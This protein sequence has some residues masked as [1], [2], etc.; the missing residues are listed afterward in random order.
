MIKAVAEKPRDFS[1]LAEKQKKADRRS[2]RRAIFSYSSTMILARVAM[3]VQGVFVIRW[4]EPVEMG[5][6]LSILL[7]PLYGVHAHLG[8]LNAI[9]LKVPYYNGQGKTEQAKRIE[10]VVRTNIAIYLLISLILVGLLYLLGYF[11]GKIGHGVAIVIVCAVITIGVNFYS[12]LFRSKHQF[13][14][15]GVVSIANAMLLIIGLP[16]VYYFGYDGLLIRYLV[17]S[18][19]L[20]IF[21]VAILSRELSIEFSWDETK[22]LILVGFPIMILSYGIVFF[23]SMDRTM[24]LFFLDKKAMG[25][26]ALAI[27]AAPIVSLLPGLVGQIYYPRMTEIFSA[28]GINRALAK[29]CVNASLLSAGFAAVVCLALAV[30]APPLICMLFPKYT[31]GITSMQIVLIG[32]FALSLGT[33]PNYFL[34]ST[35]QKKIQSMALV[36]GVIITLGSGCILVDNGLEGIAVAVVIGTC[37]Y[38]FLIWAIVYRSLL[39]S[40]KFRANYEGCAGIVKKT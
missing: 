37:S 40:S 12:G 15:A 4:L 7:I 34:I 29:E 23:S 25:E 2:L 10:R 8:L 6:W 35:S 31:G 20:L 19:I 11:K 36:V 32:Y 17:T 21:C 9:N 39:N 18:F 27:V 30:V 26:Y 3:T 1:Q 13:G 33:G 16:L 38:V 28:N 24:I 22:K 5:I 14:K